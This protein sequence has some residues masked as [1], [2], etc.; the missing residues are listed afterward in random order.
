MHILY[1]HQYYCPAGGWGND[2]SADFAR[3]WVAAGHQVTVVTTTAYF[4]PEHSAQRQA[5]TEL[6]ENG[7]RV[8]VWRVPYGQQMGLLRRAWAF[9][10]FA[11]RLLL[12]RRR[13]ADVIYASSTPPTVALAG[14]WLSWRWGVPW[15]LEVVDVWPTVPLG[16]GL[17]RRGLLVRALEVALRGCYR[18]ARHVVALSSGM[19]DQLVA[20][21]AP[22]DRIVVVENGTDVA[23]FVPRE[24]ARA[25][26]P[27]R[28]VYAGAMGRANA[29][30]LLLEAAERVGAGPQPWVL[31]LYGDGAEREGLAA[32]LHARPLAHVRLHAAVPK[33]E[34]PAVL[35]GAD[36]GIV[37]FAA[38]EVLQANSANKFY[39]YLAAGLP[40]LI[41]YGGW[42]AQVLAEAGCG[43]SA[44]MG[45]TAALAEQLR[46]LIGDDALRAQ[47]GRAARALA[48]ARYDRAR[49]SERVLALLEGLTR[50]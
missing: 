12:R 46:R 9:V 50:R 3:R 1:L 44:P 35:A 19:R 29:V 34:L 30:H 18:S 23:Q 26:G 36:V 20:A 32:R 43:L 11:L 8:E 17:V 10:Q 22:A 24:G 27:V 13:G 31:E 45:D 33:A 6:E 49:L 39:D 47:M 38:H 25:A 40:V 41:N 5:Y 37:C 28:V 2:R 15:V 21:E 48:V 16:M 4:P 14:R 42:Q 7:A